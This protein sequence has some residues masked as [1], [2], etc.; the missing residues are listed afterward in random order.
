MV[1]QKSRWRRFLPGKPV[2]VIAPAGDVF[3][4]AFAAIM[5]LDTQRDLP[6]AIAFQKQAAN[7]EPTAANLLALLILQAPRTARAQAQ[8]DKHPHGYQNRK[9]RLYELIDFNDSYVSTVLALPESALAGFNEKLK[10]TLDAFCKQADSRAF[11]DEQFEAITHGLSREIAVYRGALQQGLKVYMTSR[12]SD[13]FGIDMQIEEPVSERYIN[14]DVKTRSAFHFRLQELV[15]E[16]R[17]APHEQTEADSKGYWEVTNRRGDLHVRIILLR[18]DHQELGDIT[19]FTFAN[20]DELG[21]LLRQIIHERGL[22]NG[23]FG[24]NLHLS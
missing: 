13:A 6:R 20:T 23:Q 12:A 19:N 2:Q 7:R 16:G 3:K 14:V 5:K 15:S 1:A 17:M 10:A 4:G 11:T 24:I 22:S 8:M 9:D 21:L 18:I